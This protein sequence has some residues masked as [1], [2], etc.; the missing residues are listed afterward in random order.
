MEE[1]IKAKLAEMETNSEKHAA[2][3]FQL[4]FRQKVIPVCASDD[5]KLF[6]FLKRAR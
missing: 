6:F 3:K 1:Q 4:Q 2:L 5:N